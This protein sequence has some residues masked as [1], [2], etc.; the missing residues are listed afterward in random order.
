[1]HS[2][3]MRNSSPNDIWFRKNQ[4]LLSLKIAVGEKK[5]TFILPGLLSGLIIKLTGDRLTGGNN[6]TS[7]MCMWAFPKHMRLLDKPGR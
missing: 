5:I 1:M 2:V 3:I 7:H 6:H 4:A